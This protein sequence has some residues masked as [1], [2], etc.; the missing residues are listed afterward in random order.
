M[1]AHMHLPPAL[2][3]CTHKQSKNFRP[4]LFEGTCTAILKKRLREC[5]VLKKGSQWKRYMRLSTLARHAI[6]PWELLLVLAPVMSE[7]G[8]VGGE[9]SGGGG[10]DT[11]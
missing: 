10:G 2:V 3:S 4:S 1:L 5:L 6:S 11:M 8:R 7:F 9:G